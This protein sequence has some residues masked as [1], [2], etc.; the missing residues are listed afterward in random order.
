MSLDYE[1]CRCNILGFL[2]DLERSNPNKQEYL[3]RRMT[4]TNNCDEYYD[5]S[6]L[7]KIVREKKECIFE[8]NEDKKL[9]DEY[10]PQF[11]REIRNKIS[12][13]DLVK[14]EVVDSRYSG[15]YQGIFIY[16][17]AWFLY[18]KIFKFSPS[19]TYGCLAGV[20]SIYSYKEYKHYKKY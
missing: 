16:G 1:I 4:N 7:S 19:L 10:R 2:N 15:V 5:L 8:N 13:F 17:I 14:Y 20:M 11:I 12:Y 9:Y 18:R 6:T 3:L